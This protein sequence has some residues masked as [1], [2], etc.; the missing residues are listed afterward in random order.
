M[1]TIVSYFSDMPT[2]HRSFLLVGGLSFF[3]LL[4]HAAPLFS[5]PY[6]KFR[7]TGLNIFFTLTTI[8]INFSLA[9]LLVFS[10]QWVVENNFGIVQWLD[11]SLLY[12]AIVGLLMMDLIGA[13]LPHWVEHRIQWMWQFHIV[14]HTD[15][16]VDTTTANRHHPGESVIRVAF[17]TIGILIVGIP[18]WVF[19]IYQTLSLILTQ[20]NH[21]NLAFPKW[22][23]RILVTIICTPNMHRVHHHYKQP[24]SDSNYGNIFSFWDRIFSTYKVV[25]NSKLIY[26]LDTHMEVASSDHLG[27]LLKMPF[28]GYRSERYYKEKEVL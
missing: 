23:D 24:Y 5:K 26:G 12:T 27:T 8:L 20:F 1:E 3:L 4:E 28:T 18:I 17:T 10:S 21:S 7:H 16:H 22:L 6:N 14:H 2:A 13:W 19:I 11:L 15:Q 9:F 25:D